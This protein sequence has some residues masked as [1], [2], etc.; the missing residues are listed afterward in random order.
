MKDSLEKINNRLRW[1]KKEE[2]VNMKQEKKIIESKEQIGKVKE[3]R[4]EHQGHVAISN[5][6]I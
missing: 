1:Q 3:K 4:T 5:S 2:S 6:L